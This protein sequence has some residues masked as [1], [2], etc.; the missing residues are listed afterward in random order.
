M[1]LKNVLKQSSKSK[2]SPH[3]IFA[4]ESIFFVKSDSTFVYFCNIQQVVISLRYG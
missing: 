2:R 1:A 3:K 4:A